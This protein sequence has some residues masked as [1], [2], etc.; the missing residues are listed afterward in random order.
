M[1]LSVTKLNQAF[2]GYAMSYNVELIQKK[3]QIVQLEASK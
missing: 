3:D 1:Q 2:Q